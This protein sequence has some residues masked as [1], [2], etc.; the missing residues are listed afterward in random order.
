MAIS[1]PDD[2]AG[3][4]WNLDARN[5][6]GLSNNDP[7]NLWVDDSGNGIDG[8]N[9]SVGSQPLYIT[10]QL[11]SLPI[12]RADG[13]DDF[14]NM[15]PSVASGSF[16]FYAV[17]KPNAANDSIIWDAQTGRLL[18]YCYSAGSSGNVGWYDGTV[19]QVG[20]G[21]TS[22]QI[23]I[24]KLDAGSSIGTVYRDGVSIGTNTYT[25]QAIGGN[26]RIF[27]TYDGYGFGAVDL[28]QFGCYN[29]AL[30]D[31]NRGDLEDLLTDTW[32]GVS[33]PVT[34][35][36]PILVHSHKQQRMF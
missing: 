6:V 24:W 12:V 27:R 1:H 2:I 35:I 32:F 33:P 20:L 25:P 9:G 7:V 3:L 22:W 8:S 13:N 21:N 15:M 4:Q 31:V 17:I 5:I 18:L 19:R 14:L 10:N 11:N 26:T 23:L 34:P 29:S 16:T 36:L 30:N 28:A